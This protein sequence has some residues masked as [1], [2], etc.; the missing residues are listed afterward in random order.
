MEAKPPKGKRLYSRR[1]ILKKIP[2]G[3]AGGVV[4]GVVSGKLLGS[5]FRSRRRPP[6]LPEDSIFTPSEDSVRRIT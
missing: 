2:V 6:V 5:V 4:L 3:I 1:E